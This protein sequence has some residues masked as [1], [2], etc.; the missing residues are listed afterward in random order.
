ME[1]PKLKRASSSSG[2]SAPLKP[3]KFSFESS[4]SLEDCVSR[5]R[6]LDDQLLASSGKTPKGIVDAYVIYRNTTTYDFDVR[7]GGRAIGHLKALPNS[8]TL[9]LGHTRISELIVFLLSLIF[10]IAVLV[11]GNIELKF[12]WTIMAVL[13]LIFLAIPMYRTWRAAIH[14]NSTVIQLIED[15][16]LYLEPLSRSNAVSEEKNAG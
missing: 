15:T 9:V 10:G 6:R 7:A 12:D 2:L 13:G 4:L 8:H 14:L 16:L 5:L 3:L 11:I 1:K